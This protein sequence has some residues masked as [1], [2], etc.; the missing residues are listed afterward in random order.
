[1]VSA[2]AAPG[3]WLRLSWVA[4][5]TMV[6]LLMLRPSAVRSN[7]KSIDHI[8]LAASGRS[9]GWRSATGIFFRLRLL[10]CSPAFGIEPIDPFVIDDLPAFGVAF[11]V[12]HSGLFD[13]QRR[14]ALGDLLFGAMIFSFNTE[15]SI[16]SRSNIIKR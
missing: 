16:R 11:Q 3:R 13:R 9:R 1:M 8:W 2:I 5:S 10:T 15:F 12:N 14:W 4:S 7:T 6:R